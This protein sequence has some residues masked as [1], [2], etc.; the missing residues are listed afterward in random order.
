MR[1]SSPSEMPNKT[2]T[3]TKLPT[4]K[5][6]K[7]AINLWVSWTLVTAVTAAS[8]TMAWVACDVYRSIE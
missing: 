8:A 5:A 7:S 3:Q 4:Q 6:T 2:N 1:V